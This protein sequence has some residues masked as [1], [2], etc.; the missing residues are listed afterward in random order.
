MGL[1]IAGVIWAFLFEDGTK[2]RDSSALCLFWSWYNIVVLTIACI[3]CIEQPRYRSSERLSAVETAILDIDGLAYVVRVI[4]VSLGGARL[5]GAPPAKP[6]T[7]I[8]VTLGGQPCLA[9]SFASAKAISSSASMT[10]R[11]ASEAHPLGLLGPVRRRRGQHRA[12]PDRWRRPR[13]GHALR[14]PSSAALQRHG[15]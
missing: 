6:G 7:A 15:R 4:D 1:T 13:A 5:A 12:A 11:H 9:A 14:L 8:T 3:V 2:L 10:R